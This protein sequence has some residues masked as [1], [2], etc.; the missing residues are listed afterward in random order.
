M[1]DYNMSFQ[2]LTWKVNFKSE[3]HL[4]GWIQVEPYRFCE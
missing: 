4:E 2:V 3:I 1:L